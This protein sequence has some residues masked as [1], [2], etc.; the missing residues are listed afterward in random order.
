MQ[1][2]AVINSVAPRQAGDRTIYDIDVGG[3][4]YST[5]K[6]DAMRQANEHIGQL[7]TA[8]VTIKQNGEYTN[9]F[10]EGIPGA[11]P[12][13]P[14]ALGPVAAQGAPAPAPRPS[15]SRSSDPATEARITK[16]SLIKSASELVGRIYE[17]AGP[18][19]LVE[20]QD[21]ATILAKA[22]YKQVMAE[23][24]APLQA[25]PEPAP[26]PVQETAQN[27]LPDW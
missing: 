10:F 8:E 27:E 22:W 24:P 19:M 17:G 21:A 23:P 4:V 13:G 1:V 9:Y 25:V 3:Q 14:P 12:A 20:A 16:L 11:A 7:V 18:E 26:A 5:F 6:P 15:S 2:T